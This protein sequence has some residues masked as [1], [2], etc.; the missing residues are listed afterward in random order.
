MTKALSK[1]T[2]IDED[3]LAYK[4]MG[5]WNPQ[6]ISFQDLVVREK[7]SDFLSKP[8]PFY[9]AYAVEEEITDLGDAQDWSVEHKW[10]GIRSQVIIRDR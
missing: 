1:A 9:L 7:A 2:G 10:D 8:Y 5:N 3:I 6:T 4:L